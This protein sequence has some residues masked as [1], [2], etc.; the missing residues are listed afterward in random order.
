MQSFFEDYLLNLKELHKD[1]SNTLKDLPPAALDWTPAADVNSINVLVVH[2]V[3]AQRFLIG[4]AVAGEVANRDREAEFKVRGLDTETLIQRLDQ[5][6]DH[7][8]SQLNNLTINDLASP[9]QF[10]GT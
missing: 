1:I 8:R 9:A 10:S 2:T 6:F 7:I 3:G 4:E 5:S